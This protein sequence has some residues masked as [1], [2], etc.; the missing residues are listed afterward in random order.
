VSKVATYSF[1]KHKIKM[2][3]QILRKTFNITVLAI[4]LILRHSFLKITYCD[5][6][7]SMQCD[8]LIIYSL[9]PVS[10]YVPPWCRIVIA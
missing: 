8:N 10:Y 3:A 9:S 7:F 4:A 1:E 5:S 2:D 6:L